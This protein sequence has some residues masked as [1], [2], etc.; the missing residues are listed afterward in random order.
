[1]CCMHEV[2]RAVASRM[3]L[4]ADGDRLIPLDSL[5]LVAFVSALEDAT[6]RDLMSIH[7][8]AEA[9]ASV[10]TVVALVDRAPPV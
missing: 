3:G 6:G 4:L 2:V 7:L 5:T 9:F 1:M 10:E 8:V